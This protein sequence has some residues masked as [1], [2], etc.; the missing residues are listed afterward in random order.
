MPLPAIL[1]KALPPISGPDLSRHTH[2][3]GGKSLH[4]ADCTQQLL[5]AAAAKV[6]AEAA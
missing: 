5:T 1:P 6:T 2:K 3:Y 4:P